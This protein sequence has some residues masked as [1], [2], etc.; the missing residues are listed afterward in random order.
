[1]MSRNPWWM[2]LA[3]VI[4]L[5]TL[6]VKAAPFRQTDYAYSATLRLTGPG[7]AYAASIPLE[8]YRAVTH[9]D[10]RDICVVNA[11]GEVVPFAIRAP[12][13]PRRRTTAPVGLRLFPIVGPSAGSREA[14]RLRLREGQTA[15]DIERSE[16]VKRSNHPSSYLVDARALQQPIAAIRIGWD[17]GAPDFSAALRIEASDDLEHW[18]AVS[19][20]ARIVSLHYAGQAFVRDEVPIAATRAKY[21]RLSWNSVQGSPVIEDVE[22]LPM[23]S[24]TPPKRL[25]FQVAGAAT[26][27]Q[28]E[29]DFNLGSRL[30]VEQVNLLLPEL[31]SV[32]QAKFLIRVAG[33]REWRVVGAGRIY[34]LA[35]PGSEELVNEPISIPLTPRQH[36]R[37]RI[38]AAG[39][40]IGHGVPRLEVSWNPSEV[41]FLARGRG[42]FKLL[43]GDADASSL[44]LTP[45]AIL[46][47]TGAQA[48]SHRGLQPGRATLEAAQ[49]LGGTLR[50]TPTAPAPDWQRWILWA[51]LLLGV[52]VLALMARGLLKSLR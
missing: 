36:W 9:T 18:R 42:P 46:N 28:D 44:A 26:A 5:A 52:A 50:L 7:P 31:N 30:P 21:L 13:S 38:S 43:Y 48:Q 12:A 39:G 27:R 40:G 19:F 32:V 11:S 37:A 45:D 49:L 33:S 14:L 25:S 35:V 29:F 4:V 22:A 20:G 16:A 34:D 2:A 17:A 8:V 15:V 10:L 24:Y 23:A 1:M 6:P 47:P 3:G 51:V 41:V